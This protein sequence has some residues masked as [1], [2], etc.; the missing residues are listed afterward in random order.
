MAELGAALILFGILGLVDILARG[1]WNWRSNL[2]ICIGFLIG[3]YVG[4]WLTTLIFG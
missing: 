4:S 2:L 3:G 1:R